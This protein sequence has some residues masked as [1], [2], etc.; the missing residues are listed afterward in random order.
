MRAERNWYQKYHIS[1]SIH[2]YFP[3]LS[4]KLDIMEKKFMGRISSILVTFLDNK[5][6][7]ELLY[8]YKNHKPLSL[9]QFFWLSWNKY[10]TIGK[11]HNVFFFFLLSFTKTEG[12]ITFYGINACW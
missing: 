9:A 11:S 7:R 3:T 12:N 2:M 1:T 8:P 4:L 6:K 5:N 10:Q